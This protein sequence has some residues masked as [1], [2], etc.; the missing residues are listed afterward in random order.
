[1]VFLVV[2]PDS[3]MMTSTGFAMRSC[4]LLP[5]A[6]SRGPR[7]SWLG[8]LP[9]SYSHRA[10][11]S[12]Y[13]STKSIASSS[14]I[15][16]WLPRGQFLS[17]DAWLKAKRS[18]PSLVFNP[19]QRLDAF[20]PSPPVHHLFLGWLGKL[21]GESWWDGRAMWQLSRTMSTRRSILPSWRV[22]HHPEPDHA[23]PL[24]PWESCVFFCT[25]GLES[26]P[27]TARVGHGRRHAFGIGCLPWHVDVPVLR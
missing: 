12:T 7:P 14:S 15:W 9:V 10:T 3:W 13:A 5:L 26:L 23:R 16:C 25:L 21:L 18:A 24:S 4:W 20:D 6:S 27:Q 1:M 17:L 8:S 22:T 19:R 2:V 11:Y